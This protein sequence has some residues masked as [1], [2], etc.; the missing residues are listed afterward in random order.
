MSSSGRQNN[1]VNTD[2]D[3]LISVKFS[4]AVN[5]T[6]GSGAVPTLNL[7]IGFTPVSATYASG[8]GTDTLVFT[9]RILSGQTDDNGISIPVTGSSPI[10]INTGSIRDLAGNDA[11]LTFGSLGDDATLKVDT[12]VPTITGVTVTGTDS[13]GTAKTGALTVGDKIRVTIN[14]SE[15]VIVSGSTSVSINVGT[16]VGWLFG[17]PHRHL[18][19]R[20]RHQRPGVHLRNTSW[21]HRRR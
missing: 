9:Y 11:I 6:A 4:E 14:T 7:T 5:Y 12:S 20:F 21:R 16:V 2:D 13:S 17:I 1:F 18:C 3:V 8:I 19:L 15:A 10:V